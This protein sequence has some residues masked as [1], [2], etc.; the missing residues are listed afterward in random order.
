MSLS[1][2]T[3]VHLARSRTP[4]DRSRVRL[5]TAALA[6]AGALF[7]AALRLLRL[8]G[9]LSKD[10]YS[11]YVAEIGLRAGLA[12]ILV[13]LSLLAGGLAVQALRIGTAARERRLAALR[14]AGASPR[15]VRRLAAAD[16]A[17]V[18]VAGGLLAGPAYL[19]LTL[20]FGAL[21]RM[22]RI[23][24][25]VD[26]W[27]LA[28]WVI[29]ALVTTVA[30][31]AIGWFLHRPAGPGKAPRPLPPQVAPAIGAG[32]LVL[33][34]LP[35]G[36]LGYIG[37]AATVVGLAVL[38]FWLAPRFHRAL[39]RRLTTS[40]RPVTLLTG[41]RLVAD[42]RPASRM[43]TLLLCCGYLI[44]ALAQT[45]LYIVLD[46]SPRR[47]GNLEFYLTGFGLSIFGVALIAVIALSALTVGVAD[48][49][50]DQRRQLACL[51]ALG[52]DVGFLGRVVRRQLTTVAAPALA[53]GL[54][55]GLLGGINVLIGFQTDQPPT[56]WL[57]PLFVVLL[58]LGAAAGAGGAAL[59][60]YLLRN[61]LR[62]ALDPENLRAA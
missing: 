24:P 51:T 7:L 16:A 41:A 42:A 46:H 49:L 43:S 58:G 57:A 48:Q 45:S 28:G 52:V 2:A 14:L 18:G 61:Q 6:F 53:L 55:I 15:Q 23:F 25:G 62:D 56:G 59:A 29:V 33:G 20:L 13:I 32:L 50:V 3:T 26:W 27:D 44:G 21:P 38:W 35:G 40:S 37:S 17:L 22:L 19:A 9:E 36:Y 12:A 8:R 30:G 54:G 39:G 34:L 47:A 10:A 1:L 4:A 31:T 60:G 5:A 11:N